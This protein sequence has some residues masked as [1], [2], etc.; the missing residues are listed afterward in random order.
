M[1]NRLGLADRVHLRGFVDDVFPVMAAADAV[2]ISAPVHALGRTAI[3][4]MLLGK[5]VVYPLGT[6]FDDYIEN[7]ATGLGY[8]AGDPHSMADRIDDLMQNPRLGR[9]IGANARRSARTTFTR[10]GFGG[11]FYRRAL[12]LSHRTTTSD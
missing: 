10:E 8:V 5:P 7:G 4:G 12:A 2:V 11:K 1:I 3:E 6:G 9:Q